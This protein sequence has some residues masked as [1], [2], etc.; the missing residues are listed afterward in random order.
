MKEELLH[1]SHNTTVGRFRRNIASPHWH[2]DSGRATDRWGSSRCLDLLN[3]SEHS[4]DA[5]DFIRH[6]AYP[7]HTEYTH[8]HTH[9][10]NPCP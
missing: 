9:T 2:I 5:A 8:T 6:I 1:G 4:Y 3:M 7:Y 10:F